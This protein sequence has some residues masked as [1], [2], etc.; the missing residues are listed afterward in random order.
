MVFMESVFR[1]RRNPGASR[2]ALPRQEQKEPE[3]PKSTVAHAVEEAVVTESAEALPAPHPVTDLFYRARM[4]AQGEEEKPLG[5][6]IAEDADKT[7]TVL[8][9]REASGPVPVPMNREIPVHI[10]LEHFGEQE[11]E[12]RSSALRWVAGICALLL[13]FCAGL[14]V[15]H[16]IVFPQW[17]L[18]RTHA[19]APPVVQKKNPQTVPAPS[20]AQPSETAS[21]AANPAAAQPSAPANNASDASDASSEPKYLPPATVG[22]S[23]AVM[24]A[25]LVYAPPPAYPMRAEMTRTEGKVMVEAVVGK[26]GRVIR[27]R[28]ISGHQLL[29]AAALREVYARRYQ[30]Y[31]VRDRP[32]DVATIVTV[33]FHLKQ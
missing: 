31:T 16:R 8:L 19:A 23:P 11:I 1:T 25:H 18:N 26:D 12:R 22:A 5:R 21:A 28:A 17:V 13:S 15:H 27:A 7:D 14:L 29:R 32:I 3:E 24:A 6:I 20:G 9:H 10:P 2:D 30:P 4:A 33:D